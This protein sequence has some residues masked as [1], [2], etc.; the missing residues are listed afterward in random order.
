[1]CS[2]TVLGLSLS[3]R[4]M[5][6]VVFRNG[7]LVDWELR[8]FKGCWC[9]QKLEKIAAAVQVLLAQYSPTLVALKRSKPSFRAH[10][11]VV[12][13]RILSLIESTG[14]S[15][16]HIPLTAIEKLTHSNKY[17]LLQAVSQRFPV[18]AEY[19]KSKLQFLSRYYV[20]LFEA[21]AVA[22]EFVDAASI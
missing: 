14:V 19:N 6:V 3:P 13:N 1:M 12:S 17:D 18:L 5:G 21:V 9:E 11:S 22:Y 20:K 15:L 4:S 16:K 2:R 8:H 7:E 10:V